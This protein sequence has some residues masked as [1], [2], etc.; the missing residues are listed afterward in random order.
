MHKIKRS[1]LRSIADALG[2]T[3][4]TVSCILGN[5]G[6]PY[7]AETKAQVIEEAKR[8]KYRP[9]RIFAG[10]RGGL[11]G[12]A[13]VLIENKGHFLSNIINGIQD[14]F[15]ENDTVMMLT[16]NK[17]RFSSAEWES[18]AERQ[19]I[20]SLIDRRVDGIIL[21]TSNDAYDQHYFEEVWERRL[22]LILVDRS[23][24]LVNADFVGTDHEAVG[25]QAAQYLLELGH[26]R[27]LF[28]GQGSE[29]NAGLREGGFREVIGRHPDAEVGNIFWS[30][31]DFEGRLRHMLSESGHRP[32][33]L[34]CMNDW[35]ATQVARIAEEVGLS[36][37]RDLSILG[38]GDQHLSDPH[39]LSLSSFDQKPRQ[40]GEAAAMKYLQR[41]KAGM[42]TGAVDRTLIN[43][44][45]IVRGST[46][47]VPA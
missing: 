44:E 39:G 14:K 11:T 40:I 20:H 47:P 36:T 26:R 23:M 43:A 17:Y 37:P 41:V 4:T 15:W 42:G 30:E 28:C 19:A 7:A 46:G 27:L 18:D 1:S 3:S 33:G 10:I 45:L 34:F 12:I 29:C 32:T 38:C 21:N 2:L 25:R 31:E 5:R 16:Y 13:G 35:V 24:P 8:Q 6:G 9:N 22:P